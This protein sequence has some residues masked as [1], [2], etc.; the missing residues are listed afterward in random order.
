V[1]TKDVFM[2]P[3]MR[4]GHSRTDDVAPALEGGASGEPTAAKTASG[5]AEPK[6]TEL[7]PAV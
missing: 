5:K 2:R 7:T 3:M 4:L 1:R 6:D